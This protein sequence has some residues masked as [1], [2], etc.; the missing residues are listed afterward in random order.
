MRI[1][2][3]GAG[4]TGGYFGGRLA[5]AGRDVTFLVRPRR[6][7]QLRTGGLTIHGR[8]DDVTLFPELVT[9]AEL[10]GAHDLVLLAVKAYGLEQAIRELAPAVGPETV[11]LPLLNGMRHIDLLTERFGSAVLGGVCQVTTTLDANGAVHQLNDRHEIAHGVLDTAPSRLDDVGSALAGAG[12]TSRR[13]S[14]IHAEMWEKWVHVAALGAVTCLMRGLVGQVVAAPGGR[15]FAESTLAECAAV[16]AASGHPIR[17]EV[18]VRSRE[19]L[20]EPG[21]TATSSLYRDL[22]AG[23]PVEGEHVIGD[24]VRRAGEL[25]LSTPLLALARTHLGIHRSVVA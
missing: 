5:G 7:E 9:A 20:T 18:L 23:K 16:A 6:A 4:A 21:S 14:R 13:S 11:I 1:L 22:C 12:F 19:V 2:V 24:L 17:A 25:G 10:R 15:H 8:D 3:V